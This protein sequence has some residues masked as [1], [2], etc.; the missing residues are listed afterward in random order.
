MNTVLSAMSFIYLAIS[1][2][3]F[4]ADLVLLVFFF[5]LLSC[6]FP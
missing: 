3:L 5:V 4:L 2:S 6:I 1:V